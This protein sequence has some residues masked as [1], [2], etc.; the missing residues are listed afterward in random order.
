MP[1]VILGMT[2]EYQR[3]IMIRQPA[4]SDELLQSLK[5]VPDDL[6]LANDHESI[7]I[8]SPEDQAYYGHTTTV[9]YAEID[10][11]QREDSTPKTNKRA[12]KPGLLHSLGRY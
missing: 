7:T 6:L 9:N 8:A 11:A 12:G 3:L 5:D 10:S 2:K 1:L 4:T